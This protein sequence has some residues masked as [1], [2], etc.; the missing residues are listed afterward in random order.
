[1]KKITGLLAVFFMVICGASC[2]S[3]KDGSS[4][5]ASDLDTRLKLLEQR[6]EQQ[7]QFE[8]KVKEVMAAHRAYIQQLENRFQVMTNPRFQPKAT[9][10]QRKSGPKKK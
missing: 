8:K 7:E 1:M 10:E 4:M 3:S 9:G 2:F 5:N 6:I